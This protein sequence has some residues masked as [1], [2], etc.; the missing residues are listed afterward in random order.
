M[1]N[2]PIGLLDSGIGGLTVLKK[3]I[4][5]M[6]N[7]K[8]IFIGDQARLPYG[9]RSD[10]EIKLFTRQLVDFLLAKDV[11]AIIFACNTATAVAMEEIRSEIDIPVIG[12]IQSG[13]LAA[14]RVTQNNQIGVIATRATVN[15][16]AYQKEIINRLD[17]KCRIFEVATPN[18]VPLIES[19]Q[20]ITADNK[21]L[22]ASLA[23]IKQSEIDTL[24]LGCTHYPIIKEQI[25]ANLS[26]KIKIVDPADQVANYTKALLEQRDLLA[27]GRD[28]TREFYTTGDAE[29]FAKAIHRILHENK[30][31]AIKVMVG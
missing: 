5:Q 13:S 16:H 17:N 23:S 24:I 12:V 9:D 1:N 22:K 25:A 27:D 7:E 18:L 11:K 14:S 31:K 2:R 8:T 19:N 30:V 21:I 3:L 28:V 10:A 6:P 15:S 29:I 20:V 4:E 26:E